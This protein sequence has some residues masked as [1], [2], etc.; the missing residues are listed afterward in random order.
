MTVKQDAGNLL[1]FF[2]DELINKEKRIVDTQDV[3]DNIKWSSRRIDIAF[4][5]LKDNG[6]LVIGQT[7]GGNIR[8]VQIFRIIGLSPQGIGQVEDRKE[9][10]ATFGFE[11]NFGILKFSLSKEL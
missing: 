1:L 7:A 9:F 4:N 10:N 3:V 11:V 6:W 5:Y 8:G 2:Y